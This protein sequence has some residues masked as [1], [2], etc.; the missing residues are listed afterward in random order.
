MYN[1]FLPLHCAF[2]CNKLTRRVHRRRHRFSDCFCRACFFFLFFFSLFF[3]F[4]L[5]LKSNIVFGRPA[6]KSKYFLHTEKRNRRKKKST[7]HTQQMKREMRN[8]RKIESKNCESLVSTTFRLANRTIAR[9][10]FKVMLAR[11]SSK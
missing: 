1:G 10:R 3:P 6:T 7:Q 5:L 4:L 2:V 11:F 9:K 8:E